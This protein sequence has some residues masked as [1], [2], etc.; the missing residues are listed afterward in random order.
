MKNNNQHTKTVIAQAWKL[1]RA[2]GWCRQQSHNL[3][4][5]TLS[6]SHRS[7]G[8]QALWQQQGTDLSETCYT[9]LRKGQLLASI[10]Q[11]SVLMLPNRAARLK[12]RRNWQ[13]RIKRSCPDV[14]WI[15]TPREGYSTPYNTKKLWN[16]LWK[17]DS[18]VREC[19]LRTRMW[20]GKSIHCQ[21]T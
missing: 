19:I 7:S 3:K 8:L 21:T 15:L 4:W 12:G 20:S 16:H 9:S 13:S 18:Q 1:R 2:A 17:N 6:C 11:P 5:E 14:G 10:P